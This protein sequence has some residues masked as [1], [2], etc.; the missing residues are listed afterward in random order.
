MIN[1]IGY[2]D[3]VEANGRDW[4]DLL[5]YGG[6]RQYWCYG[7]ADA[8]VS[9]V[10]GPT[11]QIQIGTGIIGGH[12]VLDRITE[13]VVL[14]LPPV[15]SGRKYY[16]IYAR[17]QWETTHQTSLVIGESPPVTE[18][19][20]VRNT[21]PGT[22]DDQPLA[23]VPLDAGSTIP[24]TVIDLRVCGS[25][26]GP[27]TAFHPLARQYLTW[28]GAEVRIGSSVWRRLSNATGT[29]H[30]WVETGPDVRRQLTVLAQSQ[31]LSTPAGSGWTGGD[32]EGT[33]SQEAILDGNTVDLYLMLRKS[34]GGALVANSEGNWIDTVVATLTSACR[35]DRA[36]DFSF[37]YRG[38]MAAGDTPTVISGGGE[39]R[40]NGDIVLFGGSGPYSI[41][42]AATS[43][44][45]RAHIQFSK[46][47]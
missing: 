37:N 23:L 28:L 7:L 18:V 24:G 44:H 15:V 33:L 41:W 8:K 13:P 30:D 29:L 1:S 38:A 3:E 31:V 16:P 5:K 32:A 22:L 10:A 11:P 26:S 25:D 27:L 42:P 21:T 40:P 9:V 19:L 36:V 4:G 35:P 2:I 39:I 46:R 12:G 14:P 43:W 45:V 17:R 20:P 34:S 6:G 47:A